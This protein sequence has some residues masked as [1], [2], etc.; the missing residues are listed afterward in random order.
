MSSTSSSTIDQASPAYTAL[1]S[2]NAGFIAADVQEKVRSTRVLIA[3]CGL[4]GVI[5]EVA[6]RTGF[7]NVGV[8]DGDDIE[9]H[10]LN[11]QNFTA[12][13][14]GQFKA[15]ALA[16]RLSAIN[17]EAEIRGYNVMIDASNVHSF[18]SQYDLVIDTVDFRDPVAIRAL[19]AEARA[20]KKTIIA[21]L[22]VGWGGAAL[23]FPPDGPSLAELLGSQPANNQPAQYVDTFATMM[24][25]YANV[26]P[27]Y[28]L[29]V[30]QRILQS[31]EICPFS[32]I[33]AG[34][35]A[36]ASLTVSLAVRLLAGEQVPCAPKMLLVDP[37]SNPVICEPLPA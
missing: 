26:F 22:A 37:M 3:G 36:A 1:V 16:R 21:P 33:G 25:R 35:F 31:K 29:R 28:A 5:A 17:P 30:L 6:V 15:N 13:D 14:V 9:G 20:Q 7:A 10:N 4:G 32:Q 34:N 27:E 19:H 18:V 8:I 12:A 2:R 11:R 24:R 23:V